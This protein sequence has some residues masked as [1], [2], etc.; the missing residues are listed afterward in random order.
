MSEEKI[1]F[2]VFV[3]SVVSREV[4][5]WIGLLKIVFLSANESLFGLF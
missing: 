3:E 1:D 2:F 4:L 5:L